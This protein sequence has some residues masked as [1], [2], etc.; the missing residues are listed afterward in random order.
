VLDYID[1][2]I[3][4]KIVI[5]TRPRAFIKKTKINTCSTTF[6]FGR[7][8]ATRIRWQFYFNGSDSLFLKNYS[9]KIYTQDGNLVTTVFCLSWVK[10][11]CE[12]FCGN[13]N[14]DCF[15]TSNNWKI[16]IT[17]C[18]LKNVAQAGTRIDNNNIP[19]QRFYEG[20]LTS[21]R[22]DNELF[23]NV[24]CLSFIRTLYPAML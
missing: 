10:C 5:V 8:L 21:S 19:C 14:V 23:I 11:N 9:Q 15:I 22:P 24:I 3:Y 13:I 12:W 2:F 1:D 18:D 20:H 4:D 7:W 17:C 6:F 16:T